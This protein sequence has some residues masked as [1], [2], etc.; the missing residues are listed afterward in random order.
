VSTV[1]RQHV[2]ASSY[3]LHEKGQE[4]HVEE[5]RTM[6]PMSWVK[7]LKLLRWKAHVVEKRFRKISTTVR[8]LTA[9]TDPSHHVH[10]LGTLLGSPSR[11]ASDARSSVA[12]APLYV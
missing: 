5:E 8:Q 10:N 3:I 6:V 11:A 7:S 12:H 1:I 9:S 4:D 2:H